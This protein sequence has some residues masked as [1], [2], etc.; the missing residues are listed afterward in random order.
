M[1]QFAATAD[2]S[3]QLFLWDLASARVAQ[4]VELHG[5][6]T[7]VRWSASGNLLAVAAV[8]AGSSEKPFVA[9]FQLT[10]GEL[11]PVQKIPNVTQ[12]WISGMCFSYSEA[13]LYLVS[14]QG[15]II[16]YNSGE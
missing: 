15:H 5:A 11:T 10:N 1:P 13:A 2:T 8:P 12:N 14:S 16:V 7:C 9:I 6:A 3:G 4:R